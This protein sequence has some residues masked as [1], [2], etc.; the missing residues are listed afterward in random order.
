MATFIVKCP[1]CS[2]T[3]KFND[4]CPSCGGRV[5]WDDEVMHRGIY[6]I[7]CKFRTDHVECSQC[8]HHVPVIGDLVKYDYSDEP[9]LLRII[10]KLMRV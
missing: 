1:R 3:T 2:N 10:N 9:L 7:K 5:G 6:C 8:G 4:T